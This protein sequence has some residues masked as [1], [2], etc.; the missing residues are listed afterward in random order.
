M[1]VLRT[2]LPREQHQLLRAVAIG[3]DVRDQLEPGVLE[4]PEPEI[5][6]LDAR[7]FLRRDRESRPVEHLSRSTPRVF[8]FGSSQHRDPPQ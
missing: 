5:G 7:S 1:A 8:D 3:V 6:D 4:V 2:G